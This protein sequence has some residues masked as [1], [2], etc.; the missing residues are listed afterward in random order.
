M[1]FRHCG[2]ILVTEPGDGNGFPGKARIMIVRIVERKEKPS[3]NGK[4]KNK[5][6]K[7]SFLHKEWMKQ[8]ADI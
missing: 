1:S 8:P 2:I 4:Q 7:W 6:A 5:A 3:Q